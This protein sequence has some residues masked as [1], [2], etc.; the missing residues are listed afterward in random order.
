MNTLPVQI[1][2][3]AQILKQFALG[4][5]IE[6]RFKAIITSRNLGEGCFMCGNEDE[7]FRAAVGGL[8]L[9]YETGS[10][11]QERI[12]AEMRQLNQLSVFL[13]AAQ[14]GMAVD[15]PEADPDLKPIGLMI[16]WRE[17]EK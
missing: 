3:G 2:I 11:E 15:I 17:R 6:D 14:L 8:M 7:E 9:S 16:L 13:N 12:G 4:D 1:S 10:P 5:S